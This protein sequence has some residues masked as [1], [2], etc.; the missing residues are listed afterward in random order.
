[1]GSAMTMGF[2]DINILDLGYDV[3]LCILRVSPSV[4]SS[5][6]LPRWHT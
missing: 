5:Q 6:K 4:A 2:L 3:E 1:M